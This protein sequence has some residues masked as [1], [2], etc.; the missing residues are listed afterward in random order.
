MSGRANLTGDAPI[1]SY[2]HPM[3]YAKNPGQ[4]PTS[5][6]LLVLLGPTAKRVSALSRHSPELITKLVKW[7]F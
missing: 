7:S 5:R 1:G 6:L 4:L 2:G 3:A